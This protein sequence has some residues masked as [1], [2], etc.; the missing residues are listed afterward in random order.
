MS[1]LG[2]H[3]HSLDSKKRVFI[4][5][6]YREELGN[7]FYV[8]RSLDPCLAIYTKDDWEIFLSKMESLPESEVAELREFMLGSAQKCVL[9][10]N[11]RVIFDDL[12]LKHADIKKNIVFVGSGRQIKVWSEEAWS[13]REKNRDFD[14]MRAVM[15]DF[16]L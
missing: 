5:S 3:S 14:K 2:S 6:K 9:D 15:K 7:T 12:L 4:P 16:R 8:T 13:E 11:G 1:F 10:S